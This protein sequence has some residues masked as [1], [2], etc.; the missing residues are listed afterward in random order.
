MARFHI[1]SCMSDS[2]A[3]YLS[4][5]RCVMYVFRTATACLCLYLS[6][7]GWIFDGW[8]THDFEWTRLLRQ[9][10]KAVNIEKIG[11]CMYSAHTSIGTVQMYCETKNDG[12]K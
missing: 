7:S 1:L 8:F 2:F 6:M 9:Q 10:K 4:V 12:P 3:S 11:G 5:V